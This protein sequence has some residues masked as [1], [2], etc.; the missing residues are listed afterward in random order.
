MI[1]KFNL[2]YQ[3]EYEQDRNRLTIILANSLKLIN[4]TD[5][6]NN[7][8][9]A[10]GFAYCDINKK[11]SFYILMHKLWLNVNKTLNYYHTVY[12]NESTP[13]SQKKT[14]T[15]HIKILVNFLIAFI[16]FTKW[17]IMNGEYDAAEDYKSMIKLIKKNHAS[18]TKKYICNKPKI[19]YKDWKKIIIFCQDM[20]LKL[21]ASNALYTTVIP[22]K[23][24]SDL[25]RE[26]AQQI[27]S[28]PYL[29]T[30][31]R[32][33][34]IIEKDNKTEVSW[35][36]QKCLPLF[37]DTNNKH[38][39]KINGKSK[40]IPN[41]AWFISNCS[42]L[43]K[44][45][46]GM[47]NEQFEQFVSFFTQLITMYSQQLAFNDDEVDEKDLN[48]YQTGFGYL[49]DSDII[50]KLFWSIFDDEIL[51]TA[52]IT[53]V[54]IKSYLLISNLFISTIYRHIEPK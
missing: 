23:L 36:W 17:K 34:F 3:Y 35:I 7:N 52:K 27:L 28:I 20:G 15:T 51:D 4:M 14:I 24:S 16:D 31:Y 29:A 26:F 22:S 10:F 19:F 32:D 33:M 2:Y 39:I 46:E 53:K 48:E 43:I 50:S 38:V 12:L 42:C 1:R 44:A 18:F 49:Y 30:N 6:K 54:K 47:N 41:S 11:Q 25:L 37:A 13:K 21:I 5:A 8:Y 45:A 40:G 9:I